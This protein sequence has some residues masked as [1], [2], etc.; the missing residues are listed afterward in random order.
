MSDL[1][2]LLNIDNNSIGSSNIMK[3]ISTYVIKTIIFC[4]YKTSVPNIDRIKLTLIC[5]YFLIKKQCQSFYKNARLELFS[6]LT[7]YQV[8]DEA[9][10]EIEST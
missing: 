9:Q 8:A 1:I 4:D 2:I 5:R 7:K 6:E 3:Q 10:Y